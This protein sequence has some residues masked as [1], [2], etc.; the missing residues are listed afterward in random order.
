M[1][2]ETAKELANHQGDALSLKGLK[3]INEKCCEFLVGYKG[4]LL[5]EGIR[6]ISDKAALQ[7][8]KRKKK[9]HLKRLLSI[10]D[11]EGHLALT[12]MIV[13]QNDSGFLSLYST[14]ISTDAFRILVKF[15]GGL[16]LGGLEQMTLSDAKILRKHKG[17]LGLYGLR[18]VSDEVA[19]QLRRVK[20]KLDINLDNLPDSAAK[21]LRDAGHGADDDD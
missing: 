13:D 6:S 1:S 15:R 4:E 12:Q 5:L 2:A 3:S 7:L 21:I 8:A 11:S 20:G 16:T 18:N 14:Q 19:K 17:E 9:T 10:T